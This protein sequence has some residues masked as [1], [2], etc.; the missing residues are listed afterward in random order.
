MKSFIKSTLRVLKITR[1]PTKESFKMS[2][3]ICSLATALLGAIG[4]TIQFIAS[5]L[6]TISLPTPPRELVLYILVGLIVL[7]LAIIAYRRRRGRGV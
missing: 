6:Q 5:L 7:I 4:F 2:L 1:K 3:K